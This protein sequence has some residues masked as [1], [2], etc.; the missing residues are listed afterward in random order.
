MMENKKDMNEL[1]DTEVEAVAGGLTGMGSAGIGAEL[2]LDN[3]LP[4][5]SRPLP[6]PQDRRPL[7]FPQNRRGNKAGDLSLDDEIKKMIG[8]K[9][10]I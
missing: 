2:G 7:P 9:D 1:V 5:S 3:I 10:E 4:D 8:K 6:F